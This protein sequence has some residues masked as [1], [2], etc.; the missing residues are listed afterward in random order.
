MID[1]DFKLLFF[2]LGKI[3]INAGFFTHEQTE[4]TVLGLISVGAKLALF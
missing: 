3:D 1:E 4:D 2:I